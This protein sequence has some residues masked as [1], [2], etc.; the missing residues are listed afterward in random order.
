MSNRSAMISCL[1]A[2]VIC[3][4]GCGRGSDIKL[5]SATG[6]VTLDGKPLANASIMFNPA[7]KP[8]LAKVASARTDK[9]GG[10]TLQTD[11]RNG[12]GTATFDVTVFA[13]EES[14][15]GGS[16]PAAPAMSLGGP[17]QQPPKARKL[18]IP[19]KYTKSPDSGL[20]YTVGPKTNHFEIKLTSEQPK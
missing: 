5:Y 4:I 15:A 3:V 11:D 12:A 1:F 14:S 18:A 6:T 17:F 10:F 9:N 20:S 13:E 2:S 16:T 8:S 7:L 19:E